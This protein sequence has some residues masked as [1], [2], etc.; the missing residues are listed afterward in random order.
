MGVVWG[1]KKGTFL[2]G[3]GRREKGEGRREKGNVLTYT[4]N[5][6]HFNFTTLRFCGINIR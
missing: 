4:A 6:N 2:K 1:Y 5:G 3:K